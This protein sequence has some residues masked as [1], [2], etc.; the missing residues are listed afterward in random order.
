[1]EQYFPKK[2]QL[3]IGRETSFLPSHAQTTRPHCSRTVVQTAKA[4]FSSLWNNVWDISEKS[5]RNQNFLKEFNVI[6]EH[7]IGQMLIT[8]AP[9]LSQGV[10]TAV[11]QV[12]QRTLVLPWNNAQINLCNVS[13][14]ETTSFQ[15]IAR[16]TTDP[17][18]RI[19]NSDWN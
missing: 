16:G 5:L 18:Y 6:L 11:W 8:T 4:T 10:P 13:V 1:M 2:N 14:S 15:N 9:R 7:D 3:D 17:G 19:Y 12:M